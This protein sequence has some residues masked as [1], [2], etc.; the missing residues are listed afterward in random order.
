MN[1]GETAAFIAFAQAFPDNFMALVDTY[2]TL[3]SGVPN[4]IAVAL[5]LRDAGFTAKGLRLDS[6]DLAYLS[7]EA[8]KMLE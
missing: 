5:A 6:G 8:R 3:N 4:F 1:G 7:R 2:D